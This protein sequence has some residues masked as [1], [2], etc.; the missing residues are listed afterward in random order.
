MYEGAVTEAESGLAIG[1]ENTA[2]QLADL[3]AERTAV[4]EISADDIVDVFL[5]DARGYEA[6]PANPVK[7]RGVFDIVENGD[8]SVT[9]SVFFRSGAYRASGLTSTSQS[10]HTCGTL[11]GIFTESALSIGDL[12]CPPEIEE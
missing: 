9:F 8:G 5:T 1:L 12:E 11:T 3:L 10:R 7:T 6:G 4:S 2:R